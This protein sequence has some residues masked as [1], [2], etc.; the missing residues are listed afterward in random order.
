[1]PTQLAICLDNMLKNEALD[2]Q[3]RN[4]IARDFLKESTNP[5]SKQM[6]EKSIM[7]REK[8]FALLEKLV[9]ARKANDYDEV[10]KKTQELKDLY[11]TTFPA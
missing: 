3:R 5:E 2:S 4:E 11:F 1:M 7:Y 10:E 9:E 6:F 8:R